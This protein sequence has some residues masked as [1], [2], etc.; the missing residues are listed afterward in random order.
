MAS[1][2]ELASKKLIISDCIYNY[3]YFLLQLL[4]AVVLFLNSDFRKEKKSKSPKNS[5]NKLKHLSSNGMS[6]GSSDDDIFEDDSDSDSCS[7]IGS[8]REQ[9]YFSQTN[10]KSSPSSLFSFD[11]SKENTRSPF[12]KNS[13]FNMTKDF[14]NKSY[15]FSEINNRNEFELDKSIGSLSIGRQNRNGNNDPFF[16]TRQYN[17]TSPNIFM[18][19]PNQFPKP[20]LSP[21]R[22]T[23]GT[24]QSWV[25]GGY[26]GADSSQLLY[27]LHETGSSSSQSSGFESLTSSMYRRNV[28]SFPPSRE[29]SVSSE[30]DKRNESF[31]TSS[32]HSPKSTTSHY[33]F[34]PHKSPVYPSMKRNESI[35]IP[36]VPFD[37]N[38]GS[39]FAKPN[40]NK[41]FIPLSGPFSNSNHRS[42]P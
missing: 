1:L 42:P 5:K 14:L 41:S 22:L 23:H 16:M 21:S 33:S 38:Y 37:S 7:S 35:F 34:M 39:A 26:W 28:N 24:Q 40:P 31:N 10:F 36:S 17:C 11:N 25:A 30:C 20:I 29:E 19:S 15:N 12:S 13:Q 9:N 27:N 3:E 6:N 32:Y 18:L 8:T 2:I 4:L